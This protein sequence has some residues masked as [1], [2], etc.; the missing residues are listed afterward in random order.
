MQPRVQT[1]FALSENALYF[2]C[3][4]DFEIQRRTFPDG[5][6]LRWLLSGRIETFFPDG[7]VAFR[8]PSPEEFSLRLSS[9]HQPPARHLASLRHFVDAALDTL[10]LDE[11]LPL[12]PEAAHE[13]FANAAR[14]QE[15]SSSLARLNASLARH[16]Q[17]RRAE[18]EWREYELSTLK[19]AVYPDF[20]SDTQVVLRED[21]AVRIDWMHPTEVTPSARKKN[22]CHVRIAR[23][24]TGTTGTE[25]AEGEDLETVGL[26][27]QSAI[28]VQ[29]ADGTRI[30][31]S[32][33]ERAGQDNERTTQATPITVTRKLEWTV[34]VREDLQVNVEWTAEH[35]AP[36][37]KRLRTYSCCLRRKEITTTGDTG[38]TNRFARPHL[39]RFPLKLFKGISSRRD[40]CVSTYRVHHLCS[41][42][43]AVRQAAGEETLSVQRPSPGFASPL[44]TLLFRQAASEEKTNGGERIEDSPEHLSTLGSLRLYAVSCETGE[45]EE[46]LDRM[47]VKSFF[48]QCEADPKSMIAP[49]AQ[50]STCCENA[51]N[52]ETAFTAFRTFL[53]Y[54]EVEPG[55]W[56]DF[57]ERY[58]RYLQWEAAKAKHYIPYLVS[59]EVADFF[60]SEDR[61]YHGVVEPEIS[62]FSGKLVKLRAVADNRFVTDSGELWSS[63]ETLSRSSRKDSKLSKTETAE[64]QS[65]ASPV[66]SAKISKCK[67]VCIVRLWLWSP[68]A[69]S[70]WVA[71]F[72][73]PAAQ[74]RRDNGPQVSTRQLLFCVV[75]GKATKGEEYLL[76]FCVKAPRGMAER[77]TGKHEDFRLVYLLQNAEARREF[78]STAINAVTPVHRHATPWADD[79]LCPASASSS[80]DAS[81]CLSIA[82]IQGE[83]EGET[84]QTERRETHLSADKDAVQ[85]FGRQT[86]SPSR[87]PC[88]G[89]SVER[90]EG[91]RGREKLLSASTHQ[92][93]TREGRPC[94]ATKGEGRDKVASVKSSIY[95]VYGKPRAKHQFACPDRFISK[96]IVARKHGERSAE[97]SPNEKY[98]TVEAP[99]D[100]KIKTASMC[101]FTQPKASQVRSPKEQPQ[102][103]VEVFP[104][105]LDFGVCKVGERMRLGTR[106]RNI[107]SDVC[108]FSVALEHTGPEEA[109]EIQ[110][111]YTAGR[112]AP[113]LCLEIIADL[114]ASSPGPISAA[115]IVTHKAHLI[116]VPITAQ[117]V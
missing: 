59:P 96:M 16:S 23:P 79:D 43:V 56:R 25:A 4:E 73:D 58:F 36:S 95:N 1:K 116:R 102:R 110:L 109:F 65:A 80:R 31:I 76:C 24:P 54:P 63:E 14:G 107:D 106:V 103:L 81:P 69:T 62:C 6:V 17:T 84:R 2:G 8:N 111:F 48:E 108:R 10:P 29:A 38:D 11:E 74:L 27:C 52:T 33:S 101:P 67:R 40:S 82:R 57:Q 61:V 53:E 87:G 97:F 19:Q 71:S 75:R 26:P 93:G 21:N 12:S 47:E 3:P 105:H 94:R 72:E 45:A 55:Q 49:H 37:E 20:Q 32:V 41:L 91:G 50:P 64:T 15:F 42:Q 9:S 78:L 44:S 104:S 30:S 70:V 86:S 112:V 113:G 39:P 77:N 18:S 35:G 66:L 28:L 46:I 22:F 114:V 90:K 99:V 85:A 115:I 100:R 89:G 117:A 92:N 7:T 68:E 98:Q 83:D 60:L 88:S 13:A 34:T 5:R 51:E